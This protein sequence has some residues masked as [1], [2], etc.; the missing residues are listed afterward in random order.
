MKK[1]LLMCFSFGFALSVWAQDRVVTGK[2]TS[3]EDGSTLPG[4]TITIKGTSLGTSTDVDGN[5]KLSVPSSGGVLTFSFIGLKTLEE[6]IGERQVVD[7]SMEQDAT[8]LS[9]VVVTGY[10]QEITKRDITGSVVSVKGESFQNLPTQTMDRALQ[11]RAAGVQISATSGQPGGALQVR[12]RGVG[13]IN[14]DN[15]PL[16]I[17]D[18]IQVANTGTTGQGSSNPLAS[19][20]PN[21][22]E[23]IQILKDAASSAIYG[24]QSA[25]GVIIVTTKSG[26]RGKAEKTQIDL[27]AQ[28]GWVQPQNLYKVLNGQ[29][30]ATIAAEADVN[31]GID[32]ATDAYA[33][34]GNPSNPSSITNYDWVKALFHTGHMRSYDLSVR[35]G[36]AKTSILFSGSYQK[37]EGQV[38]KSDW[39]RVTGRLNVTTHGLNDKLTVSAKISV[40]YNRTYGTIADGYYVNG[41]WSAAFLM[42]P[43]QP[44]VD[45]TGAY[46]NYPYSSNANYNILQGVNQEVRLGRTLGT[47]SSVSANYK[48]IRGLTLSGLVGVD[49]SMNR[50]DNQRPSTIPAFAS[51]GGSASVVNRSTVDMN[52]NVTLDYN[53]KFGADEAHTIKAL[54]GY[55]YKSDQAEVVS[56]TAR[57]FSNPVLTKLIGQAATPYSITSS[58]GQYKRMGYFAKVDY[59]YKEKYL[60]SGTIRRDGNSRF[61]MTHQWGTFYAGSLAWRLSSESFLKDV[62]FIN[63]LKIKGGYGVLGNSNIGNFTTITKM[64]SVTTDNAKAQYNGNA[65][66]SVS[67]LGNNSLTWEKEANSNIGVD[68]SLFNNRLFGT[69]EVWE[70]VNSN[71]LFSVPFLQSSGVRTTSITENVGQMKNK[72]IDIELGGVIVDKAGFNWTS[73]FNIGFLKN[74]VTKLYNGMDTLFYSGTPAPQLIVGQSSSFIY[75]LRYA[76]VNPANGIGMVYDKNGVP[77]YSPSN[78]DATIVG[79]NIPTIYGGWSNTFSYKGVT[80]DILLQYSYGNK[81]ENG[82]LYNQYSFVQGYP[83]NQSTEVL[84]RWQK[85]GDITNVPK[86]TTTG[87]I[88]G[89]DQEY[90]NTYFGTTRMVSDGSYIRLKSVVLSYNLPTKVISKAGFR[91]IRVFTQAYNLLTWTKYNGMDPEVAAANSNSGGSATTYGN[92]PLGRQYSVGLNL[93][94]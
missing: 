76:G 5:Y 24:A 41:P 17:I 85:P 1:F 31:S 82:D 61:G 86:V 45:E 3:K 9:E 79:S 39:Q 89:I 48:I 75:D 38:I 62:S 21:D 47:V 4:V 18:G 35:G 52:T 53:K 14:A 68:F 78:S 77:T 64:G 19:I 56:S 7:V 30:F 28:E 37:Q 66:L 80:L 25:N 20:N 74:R 90:F 6:T 71:L 11:G 15:Q 72:G 91:S 67:Q 42:V 51:Y 10:G 57:G 65:G 84:K 73:K 69:I 13:S 27:T 36:D 49:Y 59:D 34:F 29:Q 23:D 60:L 83:N 44:A 12:I 33:K 70:K 88:N 81:V 2:V 50:D 43:T 32:P 87:Y 40:A 22:I 46:V 93:G 54:V 58:W 16:W 92:Y 94:F 8:Q 55:E 63:D 26:N